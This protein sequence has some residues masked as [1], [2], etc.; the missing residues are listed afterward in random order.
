MLLFSAYSSFGAYSVSLSLSPSCKGARLP[1]LSSQSS[2]P[3]AAECWEYPERKEKW[4]HSGDLPYP[5]MSPGGTWYTHTYTHLL[6][7]TCMHWLR[8]TYWHA[9]FQ[10]KGKTEAKVFVC[11]HKEG[12]EAMT[13]GAHV[14][15]FPVHLHRWA[16]LNTFIYLRVNISR[17]FS[18]L[19]D[20]V[21]CSYHCL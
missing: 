18:D 14:Q 10:E 1:A 5:A 3:L 15:N 16:E 19:E 17:F 6:F 12:E 13:S 2:R 11:S 7:S 4:H 20:W 9:T 8:Q 21:S